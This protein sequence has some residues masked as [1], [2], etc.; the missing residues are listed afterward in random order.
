MF[1]GSGV[2]MQRRCSCGSLQTNAAIYKGK[3]ILRSVFVARNA[4]LRNVRPSLRIVMAPSRSVRNTPVSC[5][6]SVASVSRA[7]CSKRLLRPTGNRGARRDR[8]EKGGGCSARTAVMADFEHVRALHAKLPLVAKFPK[9]GAQFCIL[10]VKR[11]P[12]NAFLR[13]LEPLLKTTEAEAERLGK[14]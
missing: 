6:A 4:L 3:R 14:L 1:H 7:G 8:I 13:L 12:S 9:L 10:T 2:F 5:F 11:S